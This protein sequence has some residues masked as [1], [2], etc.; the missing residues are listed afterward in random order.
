MRAVDAENIREGGD[1]TEREMQVLACMSRGLTNTQISE[2]LGLV[3]ETTKHHVRV[4]LLKLGASNRTEAAHLARS[5][6]ILL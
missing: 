4:V 3:F 6:G 2:E 5:L 1:L